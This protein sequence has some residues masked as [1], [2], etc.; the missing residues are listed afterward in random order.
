VIISAGRV[1]AQGTLQQLL[2]GTGQNLEEMFLS[3][4]TGESR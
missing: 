3:L 1:V 4:T 2:G